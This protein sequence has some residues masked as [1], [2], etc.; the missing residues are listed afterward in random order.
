MVD[1]FSLEAVYAQKGD[2]LIL[3]FGKESE[4]HF[5]LIDGGHRGVY[6]SFLR[7]RL[8]QLQLEEPTR[9]VN[10]RLPLDLAMVSH[11]DED[12]LLGILDMF[13]HLRNEELVGER[14]PVSVEAL[15]F[16][17]F[18]DLIGK[19]A[20][21]DAVVSNLAEVASAEGG[22][23]GILPQTLVENEGLRAVVASTGQGRQLLK[24][25][26]AL[27]LDVNPEFEGEL[28]MRDGEHESVTQHAGGLN[29]TVLG[30]DKPRIDQLR[31][32]W[33]ADLKSILKK[34]KEAADAASFDDAS[35]FN[36]SSIM[37][38]AELEGKT[39]LLTG[40]GRGDDLIDG[41]KAQGKLDDS[42]KI[43]VDLFK[44]PHHGSNRNVAVDTFEHITA[45]HYV[46]SANGEHDNPDADTL[47]MLVQGRAKTRKDEFTLYFTFP[48]RAFELI[49]DAQAQ[50]KAKLRQQKE[51]LRKVHD[52]VERDK[53]KNCRVVFRDA[54]LLSVAVDLGQ[55]RVFAD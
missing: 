36:L 8:T 23:A 52:W 18:E 54:E 33:A 27:G 34:E 22:V 35:V 28:V 24:D 40:D 3:H 53:P 51:A 55:N 4:R 5:I 29:F 38:L 15:W 50:K 10:G 30:P 11:A 45:N 43:H 32:K 9:L 49:S 20:G 26:A 41:L 17:G 44:L 7:P 2:A 31:K 12:H 16:N 39:M 6:E 46:I 48:E 21:G 1:W 47:A 42:G 19:P 25:A 13:K 37:V 14:A